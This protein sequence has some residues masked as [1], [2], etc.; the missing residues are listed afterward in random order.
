MS[1]HLFE[2]MRADE[3]ERLEEELRATKEAQAIAKNR[4]ELGYTDQIDAQ[5]ELF[6]RKYP[7]YQY[8]LDYQRDM[9]DEHIERLEKDLMMVEEGDVFADIM[10]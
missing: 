10:E 2:R 5:K 4:S 7:Q 8:L 9:I 1:I 3:A 6:R